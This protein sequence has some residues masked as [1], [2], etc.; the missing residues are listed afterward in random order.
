L[1]PPKQRKFTVTTSGTSKLTIDLR[2]KRYS[3]LLKSQGIERPK[4]DVK[5]TGAGGPGDDSAA[6]DA[7]QEKSTKRKAAGAAGAKGGKGRKKVK[8]E[9]KISEEDEAPVEGAQQVKSNGVKT[10]NDEDS[11][12]EVCFALKARNG[13]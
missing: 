1:S 11:A 10:E 3:R 9:E 2:S 6:G 13:G 4:N 5:N 7:A 12:D 8:V